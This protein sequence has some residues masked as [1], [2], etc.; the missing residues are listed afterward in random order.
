MLNFLTSTKLWNLFKSIV[1]KDTKIKNNSTHI[2]IF[3]KKLY[4]STEKK[5]GYDDLKKKGKK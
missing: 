2:R 1:K 5:R 3:C 4:P